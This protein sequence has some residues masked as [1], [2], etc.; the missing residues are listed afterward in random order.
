VAGIYRSIARKLLAKVA[1]LGVNP[2]NP[3]AGIIASDHR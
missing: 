1:A 3:A 2:A